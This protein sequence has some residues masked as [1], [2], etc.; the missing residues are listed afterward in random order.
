MKAT[1]PWQGE[2]WLA[3]D[4]CVLAGY[5]GQTASHAH[6]AHQLLI[7][8]TGTV[9]A[10]VDGTLQRGPLVVIE[11][12]TPHAIVTS[13]QLAVTLFAEPLAFEVAVLQQVCERAGPDLQQ[14]V[15]HL[16]NLPRRPLHPRLAQALQRIRAIDADALPAA[17]LA[18]AAALSLSQLERLFSGQ[19]GLSVRRLVLW[20][21]L[22]LALQ[23][24]MAGCSLT[25]AA[26]HAGFAD[27]AHL[28][29]SVRRQFGIRAD[30]TLRHLRLRVL[31]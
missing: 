4:Y 15:E 1:A 14:L 30:Q 25:V 28:S 10:V 8:R 22:R 31:D 19:L 29:R 18:Q 3:A 27:S 20:Q 21:R 13:E 24:A 16:R 2:L 9:E 17:A 5:L 26:T 7:A 6:Y 11:S 12:G 23:M